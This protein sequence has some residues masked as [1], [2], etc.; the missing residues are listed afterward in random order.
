MALKKAR[1]VEIKW[2]SNQAKAKPGDSKR[3]VE[4]HFNPQTLKVSF[5]NKLTGGNQPGGSSKQATGSRETK[6]SIELLFDT[7][8]DGTDVREIT[9]KVSYFITGDDG[10]GGAGGAAKHSPPGIQFEWG[11]FVFRGV[12]DAMDETLDYFSDDGVP[13]RATITLNITRQEIEFIAGEPGQG[14]GGRQ[15]DIGPIQPL[16]TEPLAPA[17]TGDS[18]Q[19]MAG[20]NG[21]SGDWKSIAAA[22][23]I[24]DPLRLQ[25]GALID[26]NAGVSVGARLGASAGL[27]ANV[28]A[29]AG[30]SASALAKAGA[31]AG[32]SA[33]TVASANANAGASAGASVSGGAGA[34]LRA[35]RR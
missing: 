29:G 15:G 7:T 20:R 18:M 5:S 35:G 31:S 16:A 34:S 21:N 12:T 6:L 8:L 4:V 11:S 9:K 19:S 30:V 10:T 23:N 14:G 25:A 24:D 33:R 17:N 1:L 2:D 27:S 3:T 13:L 26:L 28:G 22:N 32:V